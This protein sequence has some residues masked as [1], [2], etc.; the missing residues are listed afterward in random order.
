MKNIILGSLLFLFISC[1]KPHNNTT[2]TVSVEES[3]ISNNIKEK[4]NSNSKEKDLLKDL[5]FSINGE[6]VTI[7]INQTAN[8]LKKIEIEMHGKADE[9]ERKIEK[10][11][12]NFTRDFGVEV[13]ETH[14]AIDLNKTRN[15]LQQINILMKDILLDGNTTL[16]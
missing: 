6:K 7:D 16:H 3:Q 4:S 14:V 2:S 10:Q 1:D 12:I 5:G 9:I 11:D 13:D 8:F 15:M